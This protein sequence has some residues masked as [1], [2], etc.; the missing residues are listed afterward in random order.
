MQMRQ[1][2]HLMEKSTSDVDKL[3]EISLDLYFW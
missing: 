2:Q 1:K 3:L